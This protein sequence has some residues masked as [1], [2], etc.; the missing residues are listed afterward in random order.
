MHSRKKSHTSRPSHELS[1]AIRLG[2]RG[3]LVLPANIREM[4]DLKEGDRL[5][6]TVQNDRSLRI[7][8]L[9]DLAEQM[10]GFLEGT[11]PKRSVVDELI[12]ERRKEALDE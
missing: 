9:R 8:S 7:A 1:E 10:Q 4:L 3:R 2:A 5:V 11:A 12:A 6:V